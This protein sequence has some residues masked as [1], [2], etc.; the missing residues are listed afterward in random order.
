MPDD[1]PEQSGINI[2]A[3]AA[4]TPV[5]TIVVEVSAA[6]IAPAQVQ[7]QQEPAWSPTST[8]P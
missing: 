1:L 4:G 8:I 5:S 6:D 7:G 2:T 3:F